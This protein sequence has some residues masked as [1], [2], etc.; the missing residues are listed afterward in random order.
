MRLNRKPSNRVYLVWPY[1]FALICFGFFGMLLCVGMPLGDLLCAVAS[2]QLTKND[3]QITLVASIPFLLYLGVCI[4]KGYEFLG[5]IKV[6]DTCVACCAPL[7]KAITIPFSEVQDIGVDYAIVSGQYVYWLYI[8]R[9]RIPAQYCH[10]I[11]TLPINSTYIRFILTENVY[12]VLS[13]V[14]PGDLRKRLSVSKHS[15]EQNSR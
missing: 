7:R 5:Y 1:L 8:S 13:G 9:Q 11:N 14:L 15:M 6:S 12:S 10:K 4:G 2:G 3:V